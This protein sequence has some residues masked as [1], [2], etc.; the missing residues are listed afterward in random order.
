MT[1]SATEQLLKIA[2][3]LEEQARNIRLCIAKAQRENATEKEAVMFN[4]ID[5]V[6]KHR[7][8]A[9]LPPIVPLLTDSL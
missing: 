8:E 4:Y 2:N 3:N 7:K 5:E 1:Q 9:G 6:N